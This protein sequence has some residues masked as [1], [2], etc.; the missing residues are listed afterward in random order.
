MKVAII[1]CGLIG[2]KRALALRE[3]D[4]I[5]ACCDINGNAGRIFANNFDCRFYND[6]NDAIKNS[7]ADIVIVS[8]FNKFM[9]DI[10]KKALR[11]NK[12]VLIEKPFGRNLKESKEMVSFYK[13]R[14][15]FNPNLKFKVGFNHRF[16]PAIWEAKKV[17]L[18][19]K[20]GK[21]FSIR[22][23]Y[24]HGGRKGMENEWRASKELC[25]GGELLDQGVHIIDLARWFGG[26]IN[27]VFG[28]TKTK[29]W[30]MEVEDNAYAILDTEN[31]V[32]VHFN[33]SWTNWK[34]IFSLEIFGDLG[35]VT[36][37]G[38]GGSY[39]IESLEIGM[40]REE[41]GRPFITIKEFPPE[42]NSWKNEWNEFVEAIQDRRPVIG[43]CY[44][45]LKANAVINAI[46]ESNR[47]KRV[48]EL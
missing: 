3:N 44:D 8:V 37:D 41:G 10:A 27:N 28:V 4:N 33:V 42:D 22:A 21:I 34:N 6:Y 32:T 46:Y 25:G 11:H 5:V 39:G 40:R 1:G 14:L 9:K 7:K 29:F 19:G 48:V 38:L 23:R 26:E 13:E 45:G 20:I 17:I 2:K 15:K 35:Y 30:D 16:H 43:D 24:G 36:I 31:D 12:H 18:S 47:L